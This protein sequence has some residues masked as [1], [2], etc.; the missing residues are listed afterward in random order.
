MNPHQDT[1]HHYTSIDTLEL[2]LRSRKIRFTRLDQV[3]DAREAP[4]ASGIEFNKYFFVSCWTHSRDESIPQW[5]MYS[6]AM[7]GVRITL[8]I[9]PF[10]NKRFTPPATW[11]EV[12]S[13]GSLYAPLSM[14]ESFG[15]RGFVM[16]FFFSRN[17][18]AG[19][20]EYVDDV[21]SRYEAA[22]AFGRDKTSESISIAHPELLVRTKPRDWDFQNEYR[23]SLMILPP[24]PVPVEGF[25]AENYYI[26]LPVHIGNC[27]RS[28]AAPPITY[29]DVDL[30]KSAVAELLVTVGPHCTDGDAA[31]VQEIL[32][33]FAPLGRSERSRLTGQLRQR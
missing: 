22:V 30:R 14:E 27:L 4:A 8:P 1:I 24:L 6:K 20:V 18:F 26:R 23:F 21:Q 2:I 32:R 3:D 16:P 28:K 7:S 15:E 13:S 5:H 33:R 11:K 19:P 25:M 9:Y 10:C 29:F 17:V 31:R 12:T